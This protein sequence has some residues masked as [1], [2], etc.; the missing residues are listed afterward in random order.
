[1]HGGFPASPAGPGPGSVRRGPVGFPEQAQGALPQLLR[2]P[3]R[4]SP[5]AAFGARLVLR[6]VG[7]PNSGSWSRIA[8]F[9]G[10]SVQHWRAGSGRLQASRRVELAAFELLDE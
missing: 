10:V 7:E 8:W 4:R 1:P 5:P 6:L 3:R 9:Y 2:R